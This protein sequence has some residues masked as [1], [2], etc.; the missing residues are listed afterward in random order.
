MKRIIILLSL[1]F[2][3]C[4]AAAAAGREEATPV[5]PESGFV[6]DAASAV[7]YSYKWTADKKNIILFNPEYKYYPNSDCTNYVSQCL[8]AGG[9]EADGE[10]LFIYY[11]PDEKKEMVGCGWDAGADSWI[12]P[13]ALCAYLVALGYEYAESPDPEDLAP[14]D[15]I[16]YDWDGGGVINHSA[17]VVKEGPDAKVNA[18]TN[19]RLEADWRLGA[20]LK[21]G[22]VIGAVFLSHGTE[23]ILSKGD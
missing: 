11:C 14:G 8:R 21:N 9:F 12:L 3:S 19:N 7:E 2:L 15:I 18:H 1:C 23:K 4:A 13:Y 5:K 20:D 10:T 22:A 17:I 16:F 6:Y